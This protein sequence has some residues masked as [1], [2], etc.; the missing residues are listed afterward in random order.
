MS[1]TS[2]KVR[3]CDTCGCVLSDPGESRSHIDMYSCI[4]ALRARLDEPEP[5]FSLS[6]RRLRWLTRPDADARQYMLAAGFGDGETMFTNASHELVLCL[7]DATRNRLVALLQSE[8][9]P[10]S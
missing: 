1:V 2:V 6:N 10:T 5:V 4:R 8:P 3:K 7:D 9:E